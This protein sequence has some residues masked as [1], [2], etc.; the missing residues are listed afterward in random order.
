MT[1]EERL[2]S[3]KAAWSLLGSGCLLAIIE[4]PNRLWYFDDHTSN[5]PFYHWLPDELALEFLKR[6]RNYYF[7]PV[8]ERFDETS[9]IELIRRGR[10]VSFH[11][12]ELALGDIDQ[13]K[14]R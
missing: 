2:L 11:E 9:Q 7:D 12:F 6:S 4:S 13:L 3:L 8:F 5:L 10:G 14:D 1:Y